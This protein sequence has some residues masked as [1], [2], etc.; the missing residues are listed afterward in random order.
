MKR[1]NYLLTLLISVSFGLTSCSVKEVPLNTL[2]KK[3]IKEGWQLLFDGK[4]TNG[5]R[6]YNKTTFPEVTRAIK[7]GSHFQ[8][9]SVI[10]LL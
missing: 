4:T 9:R 10:N 2:T 5:W 8:C 1:T 3:E 6:G 7:Q